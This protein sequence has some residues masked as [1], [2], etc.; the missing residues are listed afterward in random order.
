[1]QV[2]DYTARGID[3]PRG[4]QLLSPRTMAAELAAARTFF[5]DCQ[6]WGWIPSVS[7]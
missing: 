2:G 1:M 4:G 6:E 3:H 7:I 5:W